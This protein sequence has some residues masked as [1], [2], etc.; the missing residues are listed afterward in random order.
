M[1]NGVPAT[2]IV[3]K[4]SSV[5]A[6]TARQ[7]QE[8]VASYPPS[9]PWFSTPCVGAMISRME[10]N[11]EPSLEVFPFAIEDY[12]EPR[13][14]NERVPKTLT[15]IKDHSVGSLQ[16]VKETELVQRFPLAA[17]QST[18][19]SAVAMETPMVTNAQPFDRGLESHVLVDVISWEL[20]VKKM[21]TVAV[22]TFVALR[23]TLVV[24]SARVK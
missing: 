11:V 19:Q 16:D 15:V 17:P 14:K 24:V 3:A 20:S 18:N 10:M 9:V 13:P 22:D 4:N 5:F 6:Q 7:M 23:T 21:R 2:K 12:V 8:R 1:K